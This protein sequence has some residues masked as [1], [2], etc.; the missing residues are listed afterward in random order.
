L[1][2]QFRRRQRDTRELPC[3][4]SGEGIS[5]DGMEVSSDIF[6]LSQFRRV[7]NSGCARQLG[8]RIT[9]KRKTVNRYLF[10]RYPHPDSA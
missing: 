5:D 2:I 4:N 9:N 1:K 10:T 8:G 6:L 7:S 3:G